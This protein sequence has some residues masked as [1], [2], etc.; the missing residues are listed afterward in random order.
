MSEPTVATAL[1][2][3]LLPPAV[4]PP[5]ISLVAP[6]VA[7]TVLVPAATGVPLIGHEMLTPA[8]TV[9]GVAGV[10]AP[11]VTPAGRP[12]IAQVAFVAA[13]VADALLVHLSVPE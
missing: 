8:A 9:A 5:L 1:T 4:V 7:V 12:E 2:A 10:Q 13:A 6:V 3:E 11:I